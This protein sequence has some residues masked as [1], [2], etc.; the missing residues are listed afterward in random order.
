MS[1]DIVRKIRIENGKV[2][3]NYACN[4]VRPLYFHDFHVETWSALLASEGPAAL[5]L[6]ILRDYENG[7]L[8]RGANK[9]T[10]ALEVLQHMPEYK[11]FDRRVNEGY[12]TVSERRAKEE[13]AFNVLLKKALNTPTPRDKYVVKKRQYKMPGIPDDN[14]IYI[15]K[16]TTRKAFWTDLVGNA[17]I[18][19]YESDA[20]RVVSLF[21][22]ISKDWQV[23]KIA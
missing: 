1:Y 2:I 13:D 17:K 23:E 14:F 3:L 21:G 18:F 7:N 10:R 4:N 9:Y 15:R 16:L 11:L 12:A 5:D 8:Q 22:S 19:K 20:R 6:E